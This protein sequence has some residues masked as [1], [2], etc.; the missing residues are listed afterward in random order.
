MGV[1]LCWSFGGSKDV[2]TTM[3]SKVPWVCVFLIFVSFRRRVI[4]H[5]QAHKLECLLEDAREGGWCLKTL[6]AAHC[7]KSN[8]PVAGCC[9]Y[10]TPASE[11]EYHSRR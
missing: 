3:F 2:E 1:S 9:A 11:C 6:M 5:K 8:P 7:W 4:I 10:E